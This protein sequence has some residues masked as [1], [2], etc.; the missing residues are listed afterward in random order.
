[1]R[2]SISILIMTLFVILVFS[3]SS[4]FSSY[5]GTWE[6][7]DKGWR[8]NI[9]GDEDFE[10]IDDEYVIEVKGKGRYYCGEYYLIDDNIYHFDKDGYIITGWFEPYG[11]GIWIYIEE[12]GSWRTE[13]L[14]ENGKTYYFDSFS[15][16]CLNPD[17][18]EISADMAFYAWYDLFSSELIR[19]RDLDYYKNYTAAPPEYLRG[20]AEKIKN[21]IAKFESLNSNFK[22]ATTKVYY[23]EFS[24]LVEEYRKLEVYLEEYATMLESKNPAGLLEKE[25]LIDKEREKIEKLH[26]FAIN[27]L[28]EELK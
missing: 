4:Y 23:I 25:N 21:I 3:I 5:A 10:D 8:Y 12:N 20:H 13:P 28:S 2:R 14:V 19:L 17:G 22:E 1:M 11:E 16:I 6:K 9:E 26:L 24:A 7:D 15:N 18:N 27:K